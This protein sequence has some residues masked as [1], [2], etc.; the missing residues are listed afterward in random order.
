MGDR[1]ILEMKIM[2]KYVLSFLIYFVYLKK[3]PF[4]RLGPWSF[5]SS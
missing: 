1:V 3:E 4:Y 5:T 2:Q